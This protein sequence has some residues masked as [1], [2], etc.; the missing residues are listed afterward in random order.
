MNDLIKQLKDYDDRYYNDGMST[1][2]DSEYD[3][4]KEMAKGLYPNDPYFLQVGA[5]I[6]SDKK[7]RFDFIMGS[8][9]KYKPDTIEKF[10]SKFTPN[11][12]F[13]IT[14]KLDGMSIICKFVNGKLSWAASR[15]DGLEGED[16]TS[17]VSHIDFGVPCNISCLLRGEAVMRGEDYKTA[18]RDKNNVGFANRRNGVVGIAGNDDNRNNKLIHVIFYEIIEISDESIEFLGQLFG[19]GNPLIV[20]EFISINSDLS[21]KFLT[22]YYEKIKKDMFDIDLDG[23]VIQPLHWKRE[24]VKIPKNKISYKVNDKPTLAEVDYIEWSTSRTGRII[25]VVN[26][27]EKVLLSGAMVGRASAFNADFVETNQLGPGAI[28]NLVR[29]GEVIPYIVNI[30]SKSPTYEPLSACPSCNGSIKKVGV[31]YICANPECSDAQF[32][33]IQHWL[34][35]L[36]AEQVKEST[37]R[38]LGINSLDRLYGLTRSDI[39]YTEGFGES[40]ADTIIYEIK[41][42]LTNTPEKLLAAMGISGVGTRASEKI[43]GFIRKT[44]NT[45]E[46]DTFISFI[47]HSSFSFLS[48]IDGIGPSIV[49]KLEENLK[50][51][52]DIFA[53]VVRN[54]FTFKELKVTSNTNKGGSMISGKTVCMT[55][56]GPLPRKQLEE[57]IEAAGGINAPMNKDTQI[58]VCK[59]PDSG[60][61]KLQKA[62]KFGTKIISYA[63]LMEQLDA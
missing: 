10:L 56:A 45:N 61:S 14:P 15:G 17:K 47:S 41:K 19:E 29:S 54:G 35:E 51:I 44:L 24:N 1:V 28:I 40:S 3:T 22:E 39:L 33:K 4:L 7:I 58:L 57:M 6:K 55:G 63:E 53:L 50:L 27:K 62:V 49:S 36:G 18:V 21:T 48:S 31:D 42:T 2:S 30:V 16:I 23:L 9:E 12:N 46:E 34:V 32:L 43:F 37:L 8:L 59:D 13:V 52:R 60:S 26:L 5:Q 38:A 11:E 25:P 20:N